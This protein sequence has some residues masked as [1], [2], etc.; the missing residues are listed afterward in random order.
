MVATK[1]MLYKFSADDKVR[2]E[3]EQ[4][5]KAWRDRKAVYEYMLDEAMLKKDTEIVRK[6]KAYGDS[7]EKIQAITGLSI[8]VINT[9]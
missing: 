4:H 2:A 9:L 7:I 5:Q 3:Y 8:E 6:M 1:N